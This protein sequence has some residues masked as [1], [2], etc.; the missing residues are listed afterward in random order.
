MEEIKSSCSSSSSSVVK[1]EE[2]EM[3][4]GS[5][6]LIATL[7]VENRGDGLP[8]YLFKGCWCP[9]F[10]FRGLIAA[11]L[12]F[13]AQDSDIILASLTKSGTTWLKALIFSIVNR[14]KCAL[15]DSPVLTTQPH[16]LMPFIEFDLY[17][18]G[19]LPENLHQLPQPRLFSTHS[20][21][22]LLAHSIRHSCCRIVYVCRKPL[23]NLVST[24]HFLKPL[25]ENH[26]DM[27]VIVAYWKTDFGPF[28]DNVLGYWNASLE[29][30][31]KVLFMKYE[32]LKVDI[33]FELKR[34]A[35]FLG[36]PFSVEEEKEGLMEEVSKLCSFEKLKNVEVNQIG[37]RVGTGAPVNAFFR[38]GKVGDYV[39]HI[40]P[41]M[42]ENLKKLTEE[43]FAGSGL[44]YN[45]SSSN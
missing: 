20:H 30:P 22:S 23:D 1:D 36:F 21:Y 12:H 40:T 32:D 11:D 6:E 29:N 35:K 16:D 34:L 28:W 39:N 41:A 4:K 10:A 8:L 44:V 15:K 25:D 5:E 9:S 7:P 14:K 31:D 26:Q 3:K 42:V 24:W 13:Q 37:K 38:N 18:H 45:Y 33:V 43:K 27:D 19:N 17:R 2:E